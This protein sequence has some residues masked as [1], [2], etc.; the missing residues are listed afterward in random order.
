MRQPLVFASVSTRRSSPRKPSAAIALPLLSH[1]STLIAARRHSPDPAREALRNARA[2]VH[3][4]RC[5]WCG[6][7]RRAKGSALS[8]RELEQIFGAVATCAVVDIAD[9]EPEVAVARARSC[10]LSPQRLMQLAGISDPFDDNSLAL[11]DA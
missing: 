9:A 8:P 10:G 5:E 2:L 7:G 6:G 1:R 4:V 3:V 11:Q